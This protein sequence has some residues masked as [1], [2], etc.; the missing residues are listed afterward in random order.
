MNYEYNDFRNKPEPPSW[1]EWQVPNELGFD[2]IF[3]M[4]LFLFGIPFLL[5]GAVFTPAGMLINVFV[6]DYFIYIGYKSKG[7]L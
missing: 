5:F 1:L 3:K 7:M 6:I 4:L 2:Y